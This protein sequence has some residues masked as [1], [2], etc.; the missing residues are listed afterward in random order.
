MLF[1]SLNFALFLPVVFLLYWLVFHKNLKHQ[2]ILLLVSSYFFYACWDWRFLFLLVFSTL[3]DYFTGIKMEES[4]SEKQKTFWFWLSIS[5][6]LGFL[7]VF[8]Y[9]NFFA[10]SF[11]NAIANVGLEIN[12]WTL[13][14]ILP[15]GISFYT[16][17]GL[18]YVID[19]YKNRI[20]AEKNFIEY[21]VFV[22]FFP[23]LVAGPIERAT[24]LLPQIKEKRTFNYTNAVDGLRQI[25]WGLFKK[26]V[27]ADQCAEHAN[28]IFNNYQNYSSLGLIAG[29]VFFS[30]QI[31][32]DFSGYS[33]IA[34]GVARLFGINLLRNFA[35]PYFS[36]DIAEFW[37]RWHISL[38]SWFKDYLYIPLGGS[39]GG[40][41]MKVR[42]TF[43]IFLVSGFW[44]GANWTF[45]IWGLLNALFIMPSIIFNT[46]RS[47]IEIVAKGKTFP[48]LKEF[49]S[50][51]TTFA[52]AV[53]AWIFFRAEN[54]E[55]AINF[56][57][58]ILSNAS[59]VT[60]LKV[61]GYLI[62]IILFFLIV[63]W[64]GREEQFALAKI[65][66]NWKSPIRYALYFTLIIMLFW[67]GGKEQQ[68]I[69]FEF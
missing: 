43:I 28:T 10:T 50:I 32:C 20:K 41:W 23:L 14:V 22:S 19:I 46:N 69:Y 45:I 55:H 13:K 63:E 27:I 30:I 51:L 35:F 57:S 65:G 56:I 4:K 64:F 16:F 52:L 12:P 2:N 62:F 48:T 36:R 33:D 42:N 60:E 47:N 58:R 61:R 11:A 54:L 21:S 1:N 15:V 67:F 25:L 34:L 8:K 26:I 37:R 9:Y 66:L 40:T 17:H 29:A 7:G 5:I 39:K 38:S 18:S 53:F 68:F 24:H 31:Y 3:L 6:N 49:L 44:H 59:F